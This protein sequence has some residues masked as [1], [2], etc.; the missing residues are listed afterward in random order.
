ML[1]DSPSPKQTDCEE[2]DSRELGRAVEFGKTLGMTAKITRSMVQIQHS[3]SHPAPLGARLGPA[4]WSDLDDLVAVGGGGRE[5]RPMRKQLVV[6]IGVVR[7][8]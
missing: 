1:Y 6:R 4:T 5:R 3:S 2:P 7:V 8:I